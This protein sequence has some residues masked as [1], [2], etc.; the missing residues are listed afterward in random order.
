MRMTNEDWPQTGRGWTQ[1]EAV[2]YE[3]ACE[4]LTGMV[5]WCSSDIAKEE[6]QTAPDVDHIHAL[7]EEIGRYERERRQLDPADHDEVARV[8]QMYGAKLRAHYAELRATDED[9]S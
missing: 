2:A 9:P 4:L 3:V 5:A 8:T 6:Q 7:E 1:D